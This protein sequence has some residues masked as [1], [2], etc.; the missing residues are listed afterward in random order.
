MRARVVLAA[1]DGMAN[2]R[3]AA[4]ACREA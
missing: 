3:I 1:A 4:S 2:E